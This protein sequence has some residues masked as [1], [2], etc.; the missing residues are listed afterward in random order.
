MAIQ[1]YIK[2]FAKS[3]PVRFL[4]VTFTIFCLYSVNSYSDF[5]SGDWRRLVGA[6]DVVP[7]T[8]L[9]WNLLRYKTFSFDESVQHLRRF[10]NWNNDPSYFV[11][12]GGHYFSAYPSLVG[13]APLP[14]FFIAYSLGKI[15]HI[16][17]L[18]NL[19]KVAYL[20]RISASIL[21]ALSVV[22]FFRIL[23]MISSSRV[24]VVL[25]SLFYALGT[26]SWSISSRGLWQHTLSQLLISVIAYLLISKFDK[27][28][29]VPWLGFLLGASV[30]ARP[31]NIIFAVVISAYVFL[32][33]RKLFAK[34]FLCSLIWVFA[35][36]IYNYFIFGSPFSEGYGVRD[37]F[38][39]TTPLEVGI[40]GYL[41]SP[42][43]S[44]LFVSPPL[45][46]AFISMYR[47]FK[48]K[49]YQKDRNLI[50]RYLSIGFILS[51]LMF[52]KWYTWNG[53]NGFGYRML[54]DYLPIVTLLSFLVFIRLN[55]I[56]K[57]AV[58][59]LI[60]YS[61]YIQANAVFFHYSRCGGD[62]DWDYYC[63]HP[64]KEKI[65]EVLKNVSNK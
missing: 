60:L 51:T 38:R 6:G 46:L 62:H 15:S 52:A 19:L 48:D 64:P 1:R 39:W 2:T 8:Y 3:S 31:T 61:I 22:V 36:F 14:V 23:S 63:L 12:I 58:F 26:N 57:T 65:S 18:Y 45:V 9:S 25:F 11:K 5:K 40:V 21:T 7:N 56:L 59:V 44:F 49:K 41:F 32:E 34:F 37:D 30:F 53:A 54:T 13:L 55:R 28:K 10:E 4:L 43:R 50:L 24:W 42:A 17:D 29:V 47:L 27:K 20:A 33:Q 35:M 16:G